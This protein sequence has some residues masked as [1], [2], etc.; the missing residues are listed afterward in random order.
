MWLYLIAL[1]LCGSCE[2]VSQLPVITAFPPNF[3]ASTQDKILP[4]TIV[5]NNG[6]LNDALRVRC[7]FFFKSP[8]SQL[9]NP[10][11]VFAQRMAGNAFNCTLPSTVSD[12][13]KNNDV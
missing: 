6:P 11:S 7:E 1:V 8:P 2:V 12:R 9:A 4:A 13:V 10:R 5:Q 3:S